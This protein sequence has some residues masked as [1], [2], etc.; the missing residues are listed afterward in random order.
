MEIV[1][2][3]GKKRGNQNADM[4]VNIWLQIDEFKMSLEMYREQEMQE[5][6][7]FTT[8]SIVKVLQRTAE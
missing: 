2:I 6:Q 3:S 1:I 7:A 8:M 4:S 5:K